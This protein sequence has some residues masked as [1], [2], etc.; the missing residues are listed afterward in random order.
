MYGQYPD[1]YQNQPQAETKKTSK[2][3]LGA[4][5]FIIIIS[6]ILGGAATGTSVYFAIKNNNQNELTQLSGEVDMLKNT[7]KQIN[8]STSPQNI[9]INTDSTGV[10]AIAEKVK[11]SIVGIQLTVPSSRVQ[12]GFFSYDTQPQSS[13]GSG[14]ILSD[15]GYI[16]TNYHVIESAIGNSSAILQVVLNDGTTYD[17]KVIGHDSQND[18]AVIKIEALGL[19]A[20]ELGNSSEL[21]VGEIA[22]AIGNPL[23]LQFAG[24]VTVGYISALDRNLNGENT[25][26]TLI[27][28]DAA[29]NPGNS[30]GALINGKGQVIGITSSKISSTDVEGLNFAIPIS[31][32]S[33]IFNDIMEYGYVKDRPATGITGQEVTTTMA[34][35]YNVPQGLY[36]TA[37]E[38]DSGAANADIQVGDIIVSV[39]DTPIK[40]MSDLKAI[41]KNH[42]VGDVLSFTIYRKDSKFTVAVTLSEDKGG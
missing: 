42:S 5:V 21:K 32:A 4:V 2:I 24:S 26:E 31:F 25:S 30:G 11:P 37:V 38:K 12:N 23:G 27:Q 16:G 7:I 17:A 14:V 29:I 6:I 15:D 19:P 35:W 8:T 33:P 28:T 41:N 13:S 18:L 1:P 34:H 9:K 39:D 40:S 10:T 3:S 20:A 36:V 22:V